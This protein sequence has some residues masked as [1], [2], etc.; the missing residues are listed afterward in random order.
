MTIKFSPNK[1]K[2]LKDDDVRLDIS[3]IYTIDRI[4]S[5]DDV[6]EGTSLTYGFEYHKD[7]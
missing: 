7:R 5:A 2:N 1:T 3:N 4:G 6:E